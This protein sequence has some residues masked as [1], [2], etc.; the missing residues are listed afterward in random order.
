MGGWV[1]GWVVYLEEDG[2]VLGFGC[3]CLQ[4]L[5]DVE[6]GGLEEGH[7]EAVLDFPVGGED[8]VEPGWVGGWV[9]GW[10]R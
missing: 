8:G 7:E 4:G 2:D 3:V 6:A 9:G 10:I 5:Q 1:G